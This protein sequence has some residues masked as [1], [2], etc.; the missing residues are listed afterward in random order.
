MKREEK[1]V[2]VG[3]GSFLTDLEGYRTKLRIEGEKVWVQ[4][5]ALVAAEPGYAF[6]GMVAS[7]AAGLAGY[8]AVPGGS[9]L[10]AGFMAAAGFVMFLAATEHSEPYG[11]ISAGW[12]PS[13]VLDRIGKYREEEG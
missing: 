13:M 5:L 2:L 11:R 3:S 10:L 8:A 12:Q 9:L 1:G 6:L 7:V 4:R